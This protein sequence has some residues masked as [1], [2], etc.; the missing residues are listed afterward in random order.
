MIELTLSPQ[1]ICQ[2]AASQIDLEIANPGP[3]LVT[4]ILLD[5]DL[6]VSLLLIQGAHQ[7]EIPRLEAGQRYRHGLVVRGKSPGI[8]KL[9]IEGFSFRAPDGRICNLDLDGL[10]LEVYAGVK[11]VQAS[12][13]LQVSLT[14]SPLRVEEWGS[15]KC[16]FENLGDQNLSNMRLW[17]DGP[18]TC[19]AAPMETLPSRGSVTYFLPVRPLEA[20]E[21]VPATLRVLS[22]SGANIFSSRVFMKVGGK[23][24]AVSK[25]PSPVIIQGSKV[26]ITYGD[27]SSVEVGGDAVMINPRGSIAKDSQSPPRCPT[28]GKPVNAE[29]KFCEKCGTKIS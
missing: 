11:D 22:Q 8:C 2:G 26:D 13:F 27:R 16:R 12:T 4:H 25:E 9:R 15:L 23:L 6:P 14:T 28:C 5:I 18:V 20:G 10:F 3:G 17:L 21:R 19:E 24:A 29:A 7:V 1:R